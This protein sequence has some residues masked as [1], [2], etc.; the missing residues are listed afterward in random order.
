MGLYNDEPYIVILDPNWGPEK[1]YVA[2]KRCM[3]VAAADGGGGSFIPNWMPL[4]K[5]GARV[6]EYFSDSEK[7]LVERDNR[8]RRERIRRVK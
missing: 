5:G 6:S 7:A 8:N 3:K 1:Y 2:D 4:V